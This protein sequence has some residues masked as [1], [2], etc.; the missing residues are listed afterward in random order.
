[1]ETKTCIQCK[2]SKPISEFHQNRRNADGLH[3]YCKVCNIEKSKAHIQRE[4]ERKSQT[5]ALIK[6]E[7]AAHTISEK[8]CLACKVKKP[9]AEFY[10]NS[11]RADGLAS[12]CRACS[13]AIIQKRRISLAANSS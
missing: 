1:M 12:Y 10:L 8:V 13:K 2:E 5:R 11:R 6:Q 4:K 3:S 7:W 9:A